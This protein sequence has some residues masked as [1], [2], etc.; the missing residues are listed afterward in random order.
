MKSQVSPLCSGESHNATDATRTHESIALHTR[1]I[2]GE[3]P[4]DQLRSI[5]DKESEQYLSV[6]NSSVFTNAMVYLQTSL[7][8]KLAECIVLAQECEKHRQ[9]PEDE[10]SRF[11]EY[12][13]QV[14]THKPT[15]AFDIGDL[16]VVME[17]RR[18]RTQQIIANLSNGNNVTPSI[19]ATS[20]VSVTPTSVSR[21][22]GRRNPRKDEDNEEKNEDNEDNGDNGEKDR[23]NRA[24]SHDVPIWRRIVAELRNL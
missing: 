19:S 11:I 20:A 17:V 10:F 2:N 12:V 16:V 23:I 5:N 13:E 4:T 15:D 18:K 1:P 22:Q 14:K 8:N 6:R 24:R 7:E 9:T 21:Q 3:K